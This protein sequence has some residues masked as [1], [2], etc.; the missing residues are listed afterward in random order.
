MAFQNHPKSVNPMIFHLNKYH[1]RGITG[2][3]I[4]KIYSETLGPLILDQR[5]LIAVSQPWN[6]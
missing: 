5:L 3:D 6:L 2:G 1:P 4:Q